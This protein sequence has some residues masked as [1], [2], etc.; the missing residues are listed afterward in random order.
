MVTQRVI[1][2]NPSKIKAILD[3]KAPSSINEVQRLTGR[4]AALSRFISKSAEKSLPFFKVLRKV[5]NFE[6]DTSCQW[7]FEELKKYLAKLPLLVKPCQGN[8]LYLYL[9]T[10]PQAVSSVLVREEG[11]KQMPIYYVSKVLNEA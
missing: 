6:W 1:E 4:I 8:T 5:K 3:M 11:G 7:S 9:S 10:T 2:A